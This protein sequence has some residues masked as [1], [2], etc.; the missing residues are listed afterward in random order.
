M[1]DILYID[2]NRLNSIKSDSNTNE[3]EFKLMD[4]ALVMP[5]GTQVSVQESFINKKGISGSTIEIDEPITTTIHYTYYITHSPH[6]MP[7]AD[8]RGGLGSFDAFEPSCQDVVDSSV[9]LGLREK[10][11]NGAPNITPTNDLPDSASQFFMVGGMEKPLMGVKITRYNDRSGGQSWPGDRG[12]ITPMIGKTKIHIPKGSY[13]VQEIAQLVEDQLNGNLVNVENDDLETDFI[14]EK[15]NNGT[16][17][18]TLENDRS[19]IRSTMIRVGSRNITDQQGHYRTY[20]NN[21][22]RWRTALE[23]SPGAGNGDP[24]PIFKVPFFGEKVPDDADILANGGGFVSAANAVPDTDVIGGFKPV[25]FTKAFDFNNC[26]QTHRRITEWNNGDFTPVNRITGTPPAPEK[27][28]FY[29]KRSSAWSYS[30]IC[31]AINN[32]PAGFDGAKCPPGR[33]NVNS[34]RNPIPLYHLFST[35]DKLTDRDFRQYSYNTGY[36]GAYIG[37]TN[38]KFQWDSERSAFTLNNLHQPY[39]FMSH[40]NFGNNIQEAGQEGVLLK[41]FNDKSLRDPATDTFKFD[42]P[43][44]RDYQKP[45]ERI[46]GIAIFN[47]DMET[48]RR[49]GDIDYRDATQWAQGQEQQDM[50]QFED[51]FTDRSKAQIAWKKTLW[52]KLGFKYDQLQKPDN[53]EAGNFVS[54]PLDNGRRVYG[55]TTR[56]NIT[57]S[58]IPT[59]STTFNIMEADMGDNTQQR[60]RVF[61]NFDLGTAQDDQNTQSQVNPF[62]QLIG[63]NSGNN[64]FDNTLQ[65]FSSP[66]TKITTC[67]ILTQGK[68]ILAGDLPTLSEEGYYLITSNIIDGYKDRVKRGTPIPLL[69]VAPISNLSSQDFIQ[70][71]NQMVHTIQNEMIINSIKIKILT[72]DLKNPVLQE[73]SSVILKIVRPLSVPRLIGDIDQKTDDDKKKDTKMNMIKNEK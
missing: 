23:Q 73:N 14:Q 13:S 49:E 56:A 28:P 53:W 20:M 24:R 64:T 5:A 11:W 39:R 27:I 3:W 19:V 40:D 62:P 1:A 34:E 44:L 43:A 46:S 54:D 29:I 36:F 4:E 59:C 58:M 6:F 52:H 25:F 69:G 48:A 67:P 16:Y 10:T 7:Q 51:F 70:T 60:P 61:A 22:V 57:S 35:D 55:K 71:R 32:E 21:H 50:W 30:D 68:E 72:P 41:R 8:T 38:I 9:I 31:S 65:Y 63:G 12:T 42:Y 47:W 2:C 37:A 26:L 33:N 18:G 45:Q 66:Y 15:I 17:I